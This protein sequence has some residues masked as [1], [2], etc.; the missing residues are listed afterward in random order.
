MVAD[1][2]TNEELRIHH[3]VTHSAIIITTSTLQLPRRLQVGWKILREKVVLSRRS[4]WY[5][6]KCEIG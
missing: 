5:G 2:V 3:P 1:T 4:T 6:W